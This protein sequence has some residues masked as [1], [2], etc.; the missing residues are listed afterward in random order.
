[1]D[2]GLELGRDAPLTGRRCRPSLWSVQ[3]TSASNNNTA[4]DVERAASTRERS[5]YGYQRGEGRSPLVAAL[6]WHVT[7]SPVPDGG[8][9]GRVSVEVRDLICRDACLHAH[10]SAQSLLVRWSKAG[11]QICQVACAVL[12]CAVLCAV[13]VGP[14]TRSPPLGLG[15]PASPARNRRA[16]DIAKYGVISLSLFLRRATQTPDQED[17][18]QRLGGCG[19]DA[20]PAVRSDRLTG[21]PLPSRAQY[22]TH[23]AP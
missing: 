13:L 12:C 11:W 9:F 8:R 5:G 14:G 4:S 21:P 6:V 18:R 17:K 16:V 3:A 2:V 23:Q 15:L 7:L 10:V 1:M 22:R 19:R 20:V